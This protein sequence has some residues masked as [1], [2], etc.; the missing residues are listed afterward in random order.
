MEHETNAPAIVQATSL[1]ELLHLT[2]QLLVSRGERRAP[3]RDA[4]EGVTS[5][6]EVM[7]YAGVIANPRRRL[8]W[9]DGKLYSPGLAAARF[10]YFLS[11]SDRLDEIEFYA[12]N[13]L[14]F[15]PDRLTLGGSAHGA[16]VFARL[17]GQSLYE[18]CLLCLRDDG[19]SNRAVIPAYQPGD[20]CTGPSDAPCVIAIMP[21]RR[22]TRL[23]MS[24][25]MRAQEI[26]RLLAYDIFEFTLFQEYLA[27]SLGLE[28]G[29]YYH[30]AFALHEVCRK[31]S[32][33]SPSQPEEASEP[34]EMAAMPP[35]NSTTRSMLV[36]YERKLR[37]HILDGQQMELLARLRDE[38]EPFWFDLLAAAGAHAIARRSGA[39]AAISSF[40]SS[41]LSADE[42]LVLRLELKAIET[43][44]QEKE[45]GTLSR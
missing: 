30:G 2:Q 21:Y 23:H 44:Q 45:H 14:A 3:A 35:V 43:R 28:L 34:P 4:P 39:D 22:G 26:T 10:F 8:L 5:V 25:H 41:A 6:I 38:V 18:R 13:L 1:S 15:S 31:T 32:L 29:R 16:R 33:L 37:Q 19:E 11:G 24:V 7:N 9:G 20:T 17:A 42:S 12:G 27:A 40:Q 36:G